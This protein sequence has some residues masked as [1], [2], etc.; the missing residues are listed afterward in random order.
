LTQRALEANV[1]MTKSA[2]ATIHHNPD[3]VRSSG[4]TIVA[5]EEAER[6]FH[7]NDYTTI[8]SGDLDIIR[9]EKIIKGLGIPFEFDIV[10]ICAQ[11]HGT[12]PKGV[13][14]LDYRHNI[15]KAVLDTHPLPEALLYCWDTVPPTFNRL[16]SIARSARGLPA[17]EIYLMDSG[18]AAVLGAAMDPRVRDK[19]YKVVVDV[20]TSHTVCAALHDNRLSGFVEYHTRDITLDRLEKLIPKLTDGKIDHAEI[21]KQGGHGAY[22]RDA[23]GFKNIEIIVVT[24]P[25]RKLVQDSKLP[26]FFGAPLGDNMMTGTVGVLEAICR[27]NGLKSDVNF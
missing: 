10:G 23:F 16:A 18:M 20:A 25:K 9:L 26:I 15:F 22:L 7:H 6:Y 14:H 13:S 27:H 19:K 24:G 4:I 17:T 11:D 8:T 3:K 1:V 21:L 5:D 12:P 2:A